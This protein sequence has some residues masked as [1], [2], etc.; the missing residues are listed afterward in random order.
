MIG[1]TFGLWPGALLAIAASM[2]GAG[3]AFLS[4]RVRT[5]P[6]QPRSGEGM[7][8]YVAVDVLPSMDEAVRLGKVR[9]MGSVQSCRCTSLSSSPHKSTHPGE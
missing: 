3:V 5:F 9:Q 7:L 6:F 4:V 8:R 2:T 1:Y